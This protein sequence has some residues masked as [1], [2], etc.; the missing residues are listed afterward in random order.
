L[1]KDY[2]EYLGVPLGPIGTTDGP[3][4]DAKSSD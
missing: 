2:T 4:A 1:V 3:H